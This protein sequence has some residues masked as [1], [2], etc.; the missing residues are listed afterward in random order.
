[1]RGAFGFLTQQIVSL[2]QA[3]N[4]LLMATALP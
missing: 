4:V 3:E 1:M 2:F